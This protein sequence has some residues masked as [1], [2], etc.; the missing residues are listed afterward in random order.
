M[1]K[2]SIAQV[3]IALIEVV[4]QKTQV[5]IMKNYIYEKNKSEIINYNIENPETLEK[6]LSLKKMVNNT[7]NIHSIVF[8]S[9]IQFCY[10]KK[11]EIDLNMLEYFSRNFRLFFFRENYFINDIKDLNKKKK[12]LKLFKHNNLRLVNK[13]K[14]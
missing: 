13:F 2:K 6:F 11:D 3:D 12:K 10:N 14:D 8:F 4:P 1:K 9:L 5:E 7:P